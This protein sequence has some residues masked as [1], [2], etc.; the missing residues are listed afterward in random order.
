MFQVTLYAHRVGSENTEEVSLRGGW[1]TEGVVRVGD[2]V[3][4]PAGTNS[5]FVAGLLLHLEQVG[6]DGAPRFLGYDERGREILTFIEGEVPSDC[7]LRVWTDEQITVAMK[8][9]R[10]FHDHTTGV[11]IAGAGEVV[12]HNDCGPWNVVWRN[13]T[14]VAMIDFDG[15][16]PGRRLDDLSYA[17]W[18]YL[19]LGLIELPI[20]EQRRRLSLLV[21]SYGAERDARLLDAIAGAQGK[22]RQMIESSP[23]GA[24]RDQNLA[25]ITREQQWLTNHGTALFS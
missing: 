4:R 2:S 21:A 16:A 12:C 11:E 10:N 13:D 15:A 22:M 17:A 5:I 19:N 1:V 7:G 9:L 14:P 6:F 20:S 25:Q 3:R 8:L 24:Q 23:S 18:K